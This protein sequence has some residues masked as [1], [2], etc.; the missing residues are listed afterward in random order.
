[1]GKLTRTAGRV[2]GAG[3]LVLAAAGVLVLAGAGTANARPVTTNA[4]QKLYTAAASLTV[5]ITKAPSTL[6]NEVAIVAPQL[7]QAASTGSAAVKSAV[8]ILVADLQAS[9]AS[10]HLNY[11]KLNADAAAV[12]AACAAQGTSPSGAPAT[13]GGSTA[14]V[15]DP[16]LF[17]V[18]GAA[19]LA[20]LAALGLARRSRP[21]S[22]P[23]RG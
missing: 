13:G 8:S 17:G 18:G 7:T 9:A 23:G 16:A 12:S 4:C 2:V 19:V 22:S 15:R 6:K 21:Q 3:L 10:G 14:G 11:S 5:T 20:G 1:M